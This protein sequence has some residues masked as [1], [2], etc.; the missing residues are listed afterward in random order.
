MIFCTFCHSKSP[1][2]HIKPPFDE[3]VVFFPSTELPQ[4]SKI[5]LNVFFWNGNETMHD[6]SMKQLFLDSCLREF[7]VDEI[8]NVDFS[9]ENAKH[10][11]PLRPI[12]GR[13]PTRF[14]APKIQPMAVGCHVDPTWD[15]AKT[16]TNDGINYQPQLV[17]WGFESTWRIIPGSPLRF[18]LWDPFQMA[19]A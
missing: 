3:S 5:V 11:D 16:P 19:E 18:G 6:S 10:V 14:Y 2:N 7:P 12:K 4:K 9:L 17:G 1:L 15:G 13:I 8:W